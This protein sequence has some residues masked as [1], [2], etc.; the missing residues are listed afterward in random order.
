MNHWCRW[1]SWGTSNLEKLCCYLPLYVQRPAQGWVIQGPDDFIGFR[2][3]LQVLCRK[4][5]LVWLYSHQWII[6]SKMANAAV[7]FAALGISLFKGQQ[8]SGPLAQ[9]F[10]NLL[11]SLGIPKYSHGEVAK[12]S[13]KPSLASKLHVEEV[14]W[15]LAPAL[16]VFQTDLPGCKGR[17]SAGINT[18]IYPG[19]ALSIMNTVFVGFVMSQLQYMCTDTASFSVAGLEGK[20]TSKDP[21]LSS[22]EE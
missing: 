17:L 15:G 13:T 20:H 9:I 19:W 2:C 18:W 4:D 22:L 21:S 6:R 5:F 1:V 3:S 14:E 8:R 11:T 7:A 10:F 16:G 12:G